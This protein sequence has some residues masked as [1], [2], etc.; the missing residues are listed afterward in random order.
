MKRGNGE[1]S[2]WE[3]VEYLNFTNKRLV[4]MLEDEVK[5]IFV[6][7]GGKIWDVCE[8]LEPIKGIPNVDKAKELLGHL[9]QLLEKEG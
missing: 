9:Y 1:P 7:I 4:L 8:I 2:Y 3:L 6:N 5:G